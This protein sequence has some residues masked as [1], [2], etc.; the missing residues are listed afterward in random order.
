MPDVEQIATLSIDGNLV[1]AFCASLW[2]NGEGYSCFAGICR[3]NRILPLVL[4]ERVPKAQF[5]S[6]NSIAGI[7]KNKAKILQVN[8]LILEGLRWYDE[9]RGKSESFPSSL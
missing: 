9:P 4:W 2:S 5:V 7:T 8:I 6:L 1:E 3:S